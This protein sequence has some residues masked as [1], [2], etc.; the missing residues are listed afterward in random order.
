MVT[1]FAV[2]LVAGLL[3]AVTVLWSPPSWLGR[4]ADRG[5]RF[6][7]P[8]D[9][10]QPDGAA[11]G[12]G[13]AAVEA[14]EWGLLTQAFLRRRLAALV[15]EMERLDRDPDVFA[16]AFHLMVARSAHDA[17][18]ADVSRLA[19]QPQRGTGQTLY[20]ELAVSSTGPREELE[21]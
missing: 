18:L 13:E 11:D 17:L 3:V 19:A 8:E 12:P 16:K 21:L 7:P 10:E 5:T 4:V 2:A 14:I 15:Q 20:V 9:G 1:V 6:T